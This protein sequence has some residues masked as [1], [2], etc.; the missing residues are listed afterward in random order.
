MLCCD[1]IFLLSV[2]SLGYVWVNQNSMKK[3]TLFLNSCGDATFAGGTS[4][5]AISTY[6]PSGLHA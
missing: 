4:L 2:S 6:W 3:Q 1:R 5:T